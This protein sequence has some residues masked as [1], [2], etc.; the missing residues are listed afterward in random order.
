MS[1]ELG[2]NEMGFCFRYNLIVLDNLNIGM[3]NSLPLRCP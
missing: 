2:F 1:M 3:V